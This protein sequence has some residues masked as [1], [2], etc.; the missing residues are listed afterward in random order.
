MRTTV[1]RLD[2]SGERPSSEAV[3]HLFDEEHDEDDALLYE[4]ELR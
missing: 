3:S 1:R 2:R 4:E